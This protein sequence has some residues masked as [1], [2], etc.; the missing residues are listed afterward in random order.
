LRAPNSN[1][2]PILNINSLRVI[3]LFNIAYNTSV[4]PLKLQRFNDSGCYI[5]IYYTR[6]RPAELVDNERKP[7]KDGSLEELFGTKAVIAD[8]GDARAEADAD[9]EADDADSIKLCSLLLRETVRRDRVK[10][11]C[12]ED[13]LIMVVRHPATG[14]ATLA[15]SIKFVY[16]KECNNKPRP[17]ICAPL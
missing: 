17:Y 13:I 15:I 7:P 8:N 11:L 2:K 14:R 16:H 9:E 5:I 12:Y 4:R 6:V 10:A 1:G 3:L